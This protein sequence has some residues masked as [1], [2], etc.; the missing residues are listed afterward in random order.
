[1]VFEGYLTAPEAA[2]YLGVKVETL[3]SYISRDPD[4]PEPLRIR[5]TL[6]FRPEDLD[7]WRERHP[8]RER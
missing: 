1:M 4:F 6:L 8:K 3:Y 7:A 2:D 5:R